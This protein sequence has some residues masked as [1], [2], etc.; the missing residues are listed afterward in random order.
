MFGIHTVKESSCYSFSF[1]HFVAGKFSPELG[2]GPNAFSC[3][4]GVRAASSGGEKL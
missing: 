1:L 4:C 2:G 3:G